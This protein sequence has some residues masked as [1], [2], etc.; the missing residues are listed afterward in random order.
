MN[1]NISMPIEHKNSLGTPYAGVGATEYNTWISTDVT[2]FSCYI[3]AFGYQQYRN[4]IN[5]NRN[6]EKRNN[7]INLVRPITD[8]PLHRPV[9]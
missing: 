2:A 3:P 9:L 4:L 7:R 8:D 5:S 1:M 6:N